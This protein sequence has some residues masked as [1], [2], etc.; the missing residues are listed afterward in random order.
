MEPCPGFTN[1]EQISSSGLSRCEML[2]LT[3]SRL[4]ARDCIIGTLI[5]EIV[6]FTASF[7]HPGRI[8]CTERA[9]LIA[10][11]LDTI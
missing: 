10:F 9:D 5:L 6:Q 2:T 3:L 4:P 11:L 7:K 1:L 8:L